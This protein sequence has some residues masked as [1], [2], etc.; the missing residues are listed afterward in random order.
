MGVGQQVHSPQRGGGRGR[1][2]AVRQGER[3]EEGGCF[4]QGIS[5]DTSLG[6]VLFSS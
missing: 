4:F 6:S 5:L 2:V 1:G 3:G